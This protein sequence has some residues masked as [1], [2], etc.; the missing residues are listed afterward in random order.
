MLYEQKDMLDALSTEEL[1]PAMAA[2]PGGEKTPHAVS[3]LIKLHLVREGLIPLDWR[4][5]HSLQER[6]VVTST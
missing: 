3:G 1:S 5:S 2:K 4:G 6:K